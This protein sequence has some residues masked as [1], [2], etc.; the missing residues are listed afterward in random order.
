[1]DPQVLLPAIEGGLKE[2]VDLKYKK[3]GTEGS[4]A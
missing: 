2:S 4:V 1:M 3:E